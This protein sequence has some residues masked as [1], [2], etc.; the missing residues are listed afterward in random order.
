MLSIFLLAA[1]GGRRTSNQPLRNMKPVMAVPIRFQQGDISLRSRPAGITKSATQQNMVYPS[2]ECHTR[3]SQMNLGDSSVGLY[4]VHRNCSLLREQ[5][6]RSYRVSLCNR[7]EVKAMWQCGSVAQ[8]SIA[9]DSD[10]PT[11]SDLC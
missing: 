10:T 9:H 11:Q 5:E 3:K 1:A 4:E 6:K 2:P 8:I 7:K